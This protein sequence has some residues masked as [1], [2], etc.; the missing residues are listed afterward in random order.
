MPFLQTV[1]CYWAR[2]SF[3]NKTT[4]KKQ[5]FYFLTKHR[6]TFFFHYH[7]TGPPEVFHCWSTNLPN[8]R[9]G[10]GQHK[11]QLYHPHCQW[12]DHNHKWFKHWKQPQTVLNIPYHCVLYACFIHFFFAADRNF[13]G[14]WI[15]MLRW[16]LSMKIWFQLFIFCSLQ[17]L[18]GR[19]FWI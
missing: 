18:E 4:T 13:V 17:P 16:Y 5:H 1:K 7:E 11:P 9:R 12:N 14:N 6:S 8:P 19:C 3:P 2:L 15:T 10:L